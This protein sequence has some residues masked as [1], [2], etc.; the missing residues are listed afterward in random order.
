MRL[1]LTKD[2]TDQRMGIPPVLSGPPAVICVHGGLHWRI[3]FKLL[4]FLTF[5]IF[6]IR[7]LREVLIVIAS[8]ISTISILIIVVAVRRVRTW[9]SWL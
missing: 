6:F 2:L 8:T 4:F 3:G 9:W 7:V 5:F 1:C